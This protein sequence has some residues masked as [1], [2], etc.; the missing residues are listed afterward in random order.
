MVCQMCA[1]AQSHPHPDC[2]SRLLDAAFEVFCESGYSAS[3]DAVA[4]HAG[5]ARQTIYNNFPG[6]EALFSAAMAAGV[7]E[8]FEGLE[9]GE[10]DWHARLVTFSLHF[11]ARV[12][13]PPLM[14]FRR[15]MMAEAQRFPELSKSFYF[16]TVLLCRRQLAQLISRGMQDGCLR[17][18]DPEEAAHIFLNLVLG[19]D[20]VMVLYEAGLPDPA[21]EERKVHRAIELFLRIYELPGGACATASS[22][23]S[24]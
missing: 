12:F 6:K 24:V 2:L 13:S 18:E 19:S 1:V 16:N 20:D 14:K 4:K 22:N 5:V 7:H 23:C 8:L 3:I 9:N 17:A 21:D 11:R 10:G 15:L